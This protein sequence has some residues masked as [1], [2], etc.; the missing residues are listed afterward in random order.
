MAVIAGFS[1]ALLMAIVNAAAAV[2]ADT[3][4]AEGNSNRTLL[5]IAFVISILLYI[6]TQRYIL[7]VTNTEMESV[8]R[9]IRVRIAN[10]IRRADLLPLETVGRG[11]LYSSL[12]RDTQTLSQ[13]AAPTIIAIQ[14]AIMIFFSLLYIALLKPLAFLLTVLVIGAGVFVHFRT[15]SEIMRNLQ[16][17]TGREN[18]FFGLLTH[19]LEG[20]KEVKVN[21]ARSDDLYQELNMVASSAAA[22]KTRS[23]YLFSDHYLFTQTTFFLLIASMVFIVPGLSQTAYAA[24]VTKITAATLF[25]L[26]PLSALVG[27]IPVFSHASVAIGNLGRLEGQVDQLQREAKEWDIDEYAPA[28]DFREIRFDEVQFAYRDTDGKPTL[29]LGPLSLTI[30]RGELLFVVGGNGSGKSTFLKLLTALYYPEA[31]SIDVDGTD[32]DEVGYTRYRNMF[33]A[34]FT[35]YHLFERLFGMADVP[36]DKVTELLENMKISEKTQF[37]KDR[38][39]NQELSTGQR[40]RLALIVSLLEDRA[41]YI[42]DEWAADQDPAFRRH[43]YHEILPTLKSQGKTI[44]AATHDDR[45]FDVA[46]RVIKMEGTGF[47][48]LET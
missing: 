45:F 20:F 7:R 1:N 40:K 8:V 18:Q 31:G 27:T 28:P 48:T 25:I 5:F 33:S 4:V 21:A 23:S 13:A 17:S 26:G 29:E 6:V 11:H 32:L 15:R 37:I 2:A 43:F 35:D 19:L 30:R 10:K 41:I 44:I 24:T 12:T 42:F 3:S 14:S 36:A 16:E 39:V 47:I 22:L 9:R 38:F 46:D 34:I